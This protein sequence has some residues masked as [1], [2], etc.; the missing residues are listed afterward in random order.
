MGVDGGALGIRFVLVFGGLGNPQLRL[1]PRER[2]SRKSTTDEA[3]DHFEHEYESL[4]KEAS[5][6][7]SRGVD[8]SSSKSLNLRSTSP[9]S[10]PPKR[11]SVVNASKSESESMY[12]AFLIF[13]DT[14][15]LREVEPALERSDVGV[16]G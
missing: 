5:E 11:E 15:E 3:G 1:K 7:S 6:T 2:G 13:G 10:A 4:G 9:E 8:T 16:L 14:G 12:T